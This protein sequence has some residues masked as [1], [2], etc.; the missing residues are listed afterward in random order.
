MTM[1][2]ALK[3]LLIFD[4]IV[5]VVVIPGGLA[6]NW[7]FGSWFASWGIPSKYIPAVS[8]VAAFGLL[9]L[10]FVA[11]SALLGG[12]FYWSKRTGKRYIVY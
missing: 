5:L 9:G 8:F 4:S 6:I 2:K 10:S 11:V 3:E 1:K 12:F 7:Y